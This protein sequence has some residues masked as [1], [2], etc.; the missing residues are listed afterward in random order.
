[1]LSRPPRVL[2]AVLGLSQACVFITK[3]DESQHTDA[4]GD[5]VPSDRDCNDA[6][7]LQAPDLPETCD[8]I[9]N[10]CDGDIDEG[11]FPDEDGDGFGGEAD[12][13]AC[14]SDWIA[15][16]GDCDDTDSAV[17]PGN[18]EQCNG[19]DDGCV[20]GWTEADELGRVTWT[21]GTLQQDFTAA[22]QAGTPGAPVEPELPLTGVLT[23][24][25]NTVDYSVR[26]AATDV[27]DLTIQGLPLALPDDTDPADAL[28]VLNGLSSTESGPTVSLSGEAVTITDLTI[29]GGT[30][31]AVRS[32][33]GLALTELDS[34]RLAR[35]R[36]VGNQAGEHEAAGAGLY[37]ADV[38]DAELLSL[39]VAENLAHGDTDAAGGLFVESDVHL[40]DSLFE[41]NNSGRYGGGL[42]SS[43]G[44]V[45]VLRTTFQDN[46]ANTKGGGVYVDT[47]TV[48]VLED[49]PFVGNTAAYG[50]AIAALHGVRCFG[51]DTTGEPATIFRDNHATTAGA[52]FSVESVGGLSSSGCGVWGSTVTGT[53]LE[54]FESFVAAYPDGVALA[55]NPDDD[56]YVKVTGVEWHCEVGHCRQETE[57]AQLP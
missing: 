6:S 52:V 57:A 46:T 25:R 21:D 24:C 51:P 20:D 42:V 23:V 8:G 31:T 14:F 11:L 4:D 2:L 18:P 13:K 47:E 15:R 43:G 37:I 50:G 41:Q 54:P 12:G 5:G 1:M 44:H 35:L 48:L 16:D 39:Y 29:T 34:V 26:L 33:G 55:D 53:D 36:V 27:V 9:D 45:R 56:L 49:S 28:P 30:T 3:T 17:F 10:D 7:A 22:F 40:V 32:G 38:S 19:K